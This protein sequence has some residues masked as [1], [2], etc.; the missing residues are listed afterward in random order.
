MRKPAPAV[1]AP[2]LLTL[3]GCLSAPIPEELT[4]VAPPPAVEP[5]TTREVSRLAGAGISSELIAEL[6][7]SHNV[8]QPP[9]E[10]RIVYRELYVP[11]WPSYAGGKWRIGLRI[12]CYV[13]RAVEESQVLM[14]E[15]GPEPQPLFVD[16]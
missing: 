5:L 14:S 16:P 11:L 4:D 2:W 12:G 10:G 13:R 6:I 7:R 15:P 9:R 8:P 1:L 3:T